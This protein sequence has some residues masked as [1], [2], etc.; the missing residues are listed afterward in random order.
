[1]KKAIL[2]INAITQKGFLCTVALNGAQA[3]LQAV[4]K[5]TE[6]HRSVVSTINSLIQQISK[7]VRGTPQNVALVQQRDTL[8]P[9]ANVAYAALQ[10]K[11]TL[12]TQ[13][14]ALNAAVSTDAQCVKKAQEDL[15]AF[16]TGL[17]EAK[18]AP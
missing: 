14:S 4:N 16:L 17:S 2:S 6:E 3:S 7:T 1:M 8:L 12:L 5:E 13:Q 10:P 11:S 9:R 15:N 18:K